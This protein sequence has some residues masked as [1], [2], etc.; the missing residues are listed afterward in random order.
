MVS[1][2]TPQNEHEKPFHF[3][4]SSCEYSTWVSRREGKD[5]LWNQMFVEK[6]GDNLVLKCPKCGRRNVFAY[7]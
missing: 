5:Q 4:C 7:G 1:I 3:E 2:I 6:K